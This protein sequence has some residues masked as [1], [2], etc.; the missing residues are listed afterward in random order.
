MI[1]SFIDCKNA[2]LLMMTS[3]VNCSNDGYH[4]PRLLYSP[5]NN[6]S[7]YEGKAIELINNYNNF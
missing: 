4:P 6:Y 1:G 3:D 5:T 2:S 7:S